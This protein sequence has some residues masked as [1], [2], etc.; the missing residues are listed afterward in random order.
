M[1]FQCQ[2]LKQYKIIQHKNAK[3]L[4]VP[5][6]LCGRDPFNPFG[7]LPPRVFYMHG[8]IYEHGFGCVVHHISWMGLYYM[9]RLDGTSLG[10]LSRPFQL[11]CS[12]SHITFTVIYFTISLWM[13]IQVIVNFSLLKTMS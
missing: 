7:V 11:L 1:R 8:L 10:I 12:I 2:R 5:P 13:D 6:S 3:P 4:P 9:H